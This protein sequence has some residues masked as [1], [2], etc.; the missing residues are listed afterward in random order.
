LEQID[1]EPQLTG[2]V[3]RDSRQSSP[4][5]NSG[6]DMTGQSQSRAFA[7]IPRDVICAAPSPFSAASSRNAGTDQPIVEEPPRNCATRLRSN[8]V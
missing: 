4:P 2:A 3:K 8:P 6:R 5:R 7:S 1:E